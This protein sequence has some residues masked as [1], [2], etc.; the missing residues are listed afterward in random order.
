[1][2]WWVPAA[3]QS[4]D[5]NIFNI[6]LKDLYNHWTPKVEKSGWPVKEVVLTES[7]TPG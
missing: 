3:I 1:M 2:V 5:W 7:F 4:T 6:E